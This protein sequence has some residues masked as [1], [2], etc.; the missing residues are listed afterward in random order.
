MIARLQQLENKASKYGTP[1]FLE[2]NATTEIKILEDLVSFLLHPSRISEDHD[3][4]NPQQSTCT[5]CGRET[6]RSTSTTTVYIILAGTRFSYL[7]IINKSTFCFPAPRFLPPITSFPPL[8]PNPSPF[9]SVR[10]ETPLQRS[11]LPSLTPLATELLFSHHCMSASLPTP[12]EWDPT[13]T[14]INIAGPS[15]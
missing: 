9:F 1:I 14:M 3:P 15:K 11:E 2:E 13:V 7:A 4:C 5:V 10:Y 12:R 6:H 8:L